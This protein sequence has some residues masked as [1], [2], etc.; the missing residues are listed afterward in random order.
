[1]G[2]VGNRNDRGHSERRCRC[3]G[4]APAWTGQRVRKGGAASAPR[5]VRPALG[6]GDAVGGAGGARGVRGRHGR[7]PE[8]IL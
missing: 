7:H 4:T 1:R 5:Q 2:G 3:A 8:G 6:Q